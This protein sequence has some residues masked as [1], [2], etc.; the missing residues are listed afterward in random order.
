M[1]KSIEWMMKQADRA[2]VRM[3]AR[4]EDMTTL[5][6]EEAE[7]VLDA[8]QRRKEKRFEAYAKFFDTQYRKTDRK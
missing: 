7:A 2:T 5:E 1:E 6:V 8:E 4:L 3:R